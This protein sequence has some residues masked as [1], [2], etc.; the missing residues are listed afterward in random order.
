MQRGQV[1][2]LAPDPT[3]PDS[4]ERP[5]V[6]VSRDELNRGDSVVAVPFYSQQIDRRR[7]LDHCVYIPAGTA[8]LKECVAKCDE[9]AYMRKTEFQPPR[10][11]DVTRR[12]PLN[13]MEAIIG[14]I[15]WVIRAT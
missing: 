1:W 15:Q 10:P 13:V 9:V 4:K 8:G 11:G 14:A 12:L 7:N 3:N 2:Y 6:I 5:F